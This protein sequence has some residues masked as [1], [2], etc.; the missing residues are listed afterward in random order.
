MDNVLQFRQP[1]TLAL[2]TAEI[3]LDDAKI[4]KLAHKPT[5]TDAD[6]HAWAILEER[7]SAN[8]AEAKALF[9]QL[10]GMDADDFLGAMA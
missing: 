3:L 5:L 10:T 8:K 2:V 7:M 4:S 6:Q 1:R 9:K